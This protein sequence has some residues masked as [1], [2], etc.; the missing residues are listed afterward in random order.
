ML[1]I[2]ARRCAYLLLIALVSGWLPQAQ[3]I[4]PL[5]AAAVA[6]AAPAGGALGDPPVA[7]AVPIVTQPIPN[8]LP[9]G[10]VLELA[11]A[12]DPVAIGET[13]TLSVTVSN[14]APYPAEALDVTVPTPDGALAVP[15]PGTVGPQQ[16]WRW[17]TRLDGNGSMVLTGTLRLIGNPPGAALLLRAQAMATGLTTPVQARGGALVIDRAHGVAT[18]PFTPG[19]LATLRS[20]DDQVTVLFPA[21]A[22]SRALTLRYGQTPPSGQAR[23][24]DRGRAHEGLGT[25][26]LDA[27]DTLS[28]TIHQFSQPLTIT[29]SYT[30]EQLQA[31]GLR[32]DDLTLFWYDAAQTRW[33]PLVTQVDA[34]AQTASASVDHFTPFQLSNGLSASSAYIPSLQGFQADLFTGAASYRI[35]IETPAGPGGLAPGLALSYSSG[36]SDGT[37][38]ERP[39]WQ[40]GWTGK[41]WSLS[42]EGSVARG[43][44]LAG[45]NWDYFTFVFGGRSF[46]VTRGALLPGYTDPYDTDLAHWSWHSVDENFTRVQIYWDGVGYVWRAWTKDG[47]RYDFT[48]RLWHH[49]DPTVGTTIRVYKWLLTQVTDPH[50]NLMTYDYQVDAVVF[51]SSTGETVNPTYRLREIRWAY[52]GALTTDSLGAPVRTG[53]PRYKVV[54]V[55]SAPHRWVADAHGDT[56][57]VDTEYEYPFAPNAAWEQLSQHEVYRLNQILVYSR[58]AGTYEL[59]RGL[60]L[61]YAASA[62]SLQ[63]DDYTGQKVL[64]L[65]GVQRFGKD[66]SGLPATTFTYHTDRGVGTN[67]TRPNGFNRLATID[68]GQGGTLTFTYDH[69]FAQGSTDP[70]YAPP[71]TEWSLY[72]NIYRVTQALAQD[73]TGTGKSALT[74]YSYD[75]PAVNDY[76]HAASVIYAQYPPSGNGDSRTYLARPEKREFRGH[77]QVIA[78]HYDGATTAAALLN[79]TRHWFYQGFGGLTGCLPTI[80]NGLLN[81]SDACYQVMRP[82]ESWKGQ[83]FQTE[84]WQAGGTNPLQR[85]TRT[86]SRIALPF[87]GDASTAGASNHYQRVGLW[88]AFNPEIQTI[89]ETYEGGATAVVKTTKSFYNTGCTTDTSA[90]VTASYGNP[91]CIQEL[92][93]A[94]LVRTTLRW[95]GARN[96]SAGYRVDRMWQESTYDGNG[97]LLALTNQFYDGTSAADA[98]PT[99]GELRRVT[100]Y[101]VMISRR[102]APTRWGTP[103]SAAIARS[104]TTAMA[105]AR[106]TQRTPGR[107]RGCTTARPRP[108]GRRPGRRAAAPPATTGCSTRSRP[109]S[110]TR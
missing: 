7:A 40:A 36:A 87:W 38:G 33:Q 70:A 44:N 31:R 15:G 53:T 5:P 97:Y 8:P 96:D 106:R 95:Y 56:T 59:V 25:F 86:F 57:G 45:P 85:T 22:A 19:T 13:A 91:N 76:T 103:C 50:G 10:L 1:M 2:A 108:G 65:T 21:S 99:V 52:D 81:E 63:T 72:R 60:N 24:P 98:A 12:P 26:F 64:T 14:R 90:T 100:R 61:L 35:P 105:T 82:S 102:I 71:T 88:R 92:A 101:Y 30:P 55:P 27:S 17:N 23:P 18:V 16:G 20:P 62:A 79:D 84:V 69:A 9:P 75:K 51:N 4:A 107:V 77:Q 68:N 89:R 28:A 32:A 41:G 93:G 58:Q 66:G 37:G 73:V 11:V 83:E 3:V 80:T 34:A 48:Q 6:P 49:P 78:R 109:A 74:T 43:E 47:T 67:N 54:L 29:V 110:A 42:A 94:T 39:K 46:D 104:G